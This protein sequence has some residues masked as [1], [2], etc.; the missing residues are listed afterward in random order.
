MLRTN[1][2][3]GYFVNFEEELEKKPCWIKVLFVRKGEELSHQ[4]HR[5]RDEFWY[6]I[7]GKGKALLWRNL[8][9]YPQLCEEIEMTEG[10]NIFIPRLVIHSF[11]AEEDSFIL[12][13]G[14]GECREEDIA[15]VK[16]KY[17]RV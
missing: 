7:K 9:K 10:K 15:R 3:W 13:F 6:L 16:D 8:E 11:R 4:Y 17:G 14:F 5:L 2:P 1:R 12:E